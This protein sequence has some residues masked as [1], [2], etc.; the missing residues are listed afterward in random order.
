M[1]LALPAQ[2]GH[3]V[4]QRVPGSPHRRPQ[5]SRTLPTEELCDRSA[6]TNY[7]LVSMNTEHLKKTQG[8]AAQQKDWLPRPETLPAGHPLLSRSLQRWHHADSRSRENSKHSTGRGAST[9]RA[10]SKMSRYDSKASTSIMSR[11]ASTVISMRDIASRER[12]TEKD[13]LGEVPSAH[14]RGRSEDTAGFDYDSFGRLNKDRNAPMGKKRLHWRDALQQ[15]HEEGGHN[16]LMD[17]CVAALSRGKQ[18]QWCLRVLAE[19]QSVGPQPHKITYCCAI[20]A[21]QEAGRW[22][23]AAALLQMAEAQSVKADAPMVNAAIGACGYA[24]EWET[25]LALFSDFPRR[26]L[27]ISDRSKNAVAAALGGAKEW[28][29]VLA[30]VESLLARRERLDQPMRDCLAKA[31]AC[32]R[33]EM[34]KDLTKSMA[35]ETWQA[36]LA[37]LHRAEG[38]GLRP[39]VKMHSAAIAACARAARWP[40]AVWVFGQLDKPF[41]VTATGV[42]Q[43]LG[44]ASEW[45]R[46]LQIFQH[47]RDGD[48][49][50]AEV[51]GYMR[52]TLLH[53]VRSEWRLVLGLLEEFALEADGP[54]ARI[55]MFNIGLA[56]APWQLSGSLLE[57]MDQL[58]IA[59]SAESFHAAAG[60]LP[61]R[62]S[63]VGSYGDP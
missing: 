58:S 62:E 7:Q 20:S 29:Q 57:R 23:Q 54:M 37:A 48:G 24:Q 63:D 30:L 43:A 2:V 46:A 22:R 28:R 11:A 4:G 40:E 27:Q 9:S 33:R 14:L 45:H 50:R 42:I 1:A 13:N 38:R 41:A 39:D 51:D 61:G 34:Q 21:C 35:S 10:G 26:R 12:S 3:F 17:A 56:A 55:L 31:S 18:W 8:V 16:G 6:G 53:A 49:R 32:G 60:K 25:A 5:R 52:S 47:A 44:A 15:L 19:L 59:P 36:A